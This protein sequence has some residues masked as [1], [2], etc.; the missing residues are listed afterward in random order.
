MNH[1]LNFIDAKF[2]ATSMASFTCDASVPWKKEEGKFHN[3]SYQRVQRHTQIWK[4]EATWIW[5]LDQEKHGSFPFTESNT[6]FVGRWS[7]AIHRSEHG[8]TKQVVCKKSMSSKY[9]HGWVIK[10]GN[11]E[12][13]MNIFTRSWRWHQLKIRIRKLVK[14]TCLLVT[15]AME[16]CH[17]DDRIQCTKRTQSRQKSNWVEAGREGIIAKNKWGILLLVE[18]AKGLHVAKPNSRN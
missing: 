17:E 1:H 8:L 5:E 18:L 9:L 2:S 12:Q 10:Q 13:E 4:M 3:I 7:I 15:R 16:V 14:M 11:M 6:T